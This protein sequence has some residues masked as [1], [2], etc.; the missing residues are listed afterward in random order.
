MHIRR[1]DFDHYGEYLAERNTT[2]TAF[3]QIQGTT[4]R[5]KVPPRGPKGHS[6]DERARP[7]RRHVTRP[8]RT[9]SSDWERY[10]LLLGAE[11][12]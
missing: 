1:G 6:A 12:G 5:F 7:Y 3:N 2:F 10:E 4:D 11:R 8:P 9:S